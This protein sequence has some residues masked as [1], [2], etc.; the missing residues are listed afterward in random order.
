MGRTKARSKKSIED[1]ATNNL[2][3]DNRAAE[4]PRKRGRPKK[5]IQHESEEDQQEKE[6][7]HEEQEGVLDDHF[8]PKPFFEDSGS[9][10]D[11]VNAHKQEQNEE[12]PARFLP[13]KRGRPPKAKAIAVAPEQQAK[14]KGYSR[15]KS[16]PHRA[17]GFAAK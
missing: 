10:K 16:E 14:K 15:R 6:E 1:D 13:R 12:A 9:S 4:A 17:A 2:G 7:K 5:V 3:M 8:D 11:V